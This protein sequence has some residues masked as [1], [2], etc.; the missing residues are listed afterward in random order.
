MY[1]LNMFPKRCMFA[2][3][4]LYTVFVLLF[5]GTTFGL[6][7]HPKPQVVTFCKTKSNK[8]PESVTNEPTLL[9]KLQYFRKARAH[10]WQDVH[11]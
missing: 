1:I 7:L 6:Q 4:K 10:K 8:Y 2:K 11:A 5:P 3:Q 9:P